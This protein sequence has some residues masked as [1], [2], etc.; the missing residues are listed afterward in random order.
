MVSKDEA[1][2]KELVADFESVLEYWSKLLSV[3]VERNRLLILIALL[4]S[5][6]SGE[7]SSLTFTQLKAKTKL[8]RNSL[9]YHLMVLQN[10]GL[11]EKR[12]RK[13][14]HITEEGKHVLTSIGMTEQLLRTFQ[15]T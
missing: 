12:E 9:N 6:I 15:Q 8:N 4:D 5:E 1:L 14:Y 11:I 3:A 2:T 10:M 13:P 7:T